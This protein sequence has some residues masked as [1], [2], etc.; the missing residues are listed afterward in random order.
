M[1]TRYT[2]MTA[3]DLLVKDASGA[4]FTVKS[5]SS[6]ESGIGFIKVKYPTIG[7]RKL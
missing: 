3:F 6:M 7:W 5:R 4:V 1:I 2:N